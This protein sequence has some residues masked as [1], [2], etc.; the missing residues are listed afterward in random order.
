ML[1]IDYL[2]EIS[3]SFRKQ[4]LRTALT[5]IGIAIGA[6][7]ITIMVGLGQG[8]Q[9]Y[10]EQQVMA[11]G[12][13][14]VVVVF[15]NQARQAEKF[16]EQITKAGKPAERINRT[17]EDARKERLAALERR[18]R[19]RAG[20]IQTSDRGVLRPPLEGKRLLGD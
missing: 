9:S 4:K 7:A 13:P 14:R 1:A 17:D 10:I 20:T 8:V 16:L 15:P 5:S 18:R 11:F 2:E 6:F 12:N 3:W 19:G